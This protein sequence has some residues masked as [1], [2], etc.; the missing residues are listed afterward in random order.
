[1]SLPSVIQSHLERVL[2]APGRWLT[3]LDDQ[4]A[5]V[6]DPFISDDLADAPTGRDCAW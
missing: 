4:A 2:A 5:E 1:M 3:E 6:W